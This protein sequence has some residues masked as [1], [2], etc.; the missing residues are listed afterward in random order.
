[1]VYS[2]R[3]WYL[4]IP[5]AKKPIDLLWKSSEATK[6]YFLF[7]DD[8]FLGRLKDAKD[9]LEYVSYFDIAKCLLEKLCSKRVVKKGRLLHKRQLIWIDDPEIKTIKIRCDDYCLNM[10]K[11]L[12]AFEYIVGDRMRMEHFCYE[13]LLFDNFDQ[14]EGFLLLENGLEITSDWDSG[15]RQQN[16]IRFTKGENYGTGK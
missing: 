14:L 11:V 4:F 2:I 10:H 16:Y 8:K 3:D 13:G 7:K 12:R 1:V 9:T 6:R 5:G 15:V